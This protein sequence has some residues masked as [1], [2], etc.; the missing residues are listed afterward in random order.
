MHSSGLRTIRTEQER[1]T[2]ALLTLATYA[3]V[4]ET[5]GHDVGDRLK[6]MKHVFVPAHSLFSKRMRAFNLSF[7][8]YTHGPFTREV[9]EAWEELTIAGF[10]AVSEDPRGPVTVTGDGIAF[11]RYFMGE[12]LSRPR[13][14]G[15]L[16]EIEASVDA[17]ASLSTRQLLDRVYATRAVPVG[18][19]DRVPIAEIP[20]GVY[21]TKIIEP[22]EAAAA[23]DIPA[24]WHRRFHIAYLKGIAS[25]FGEDTPAFDGLTIDELEQLDK[26]LELEERDVLEE[27]DLGEIKSRYGI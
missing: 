14:Q 22:Y 20:A 21:L 9:Y 17:T 12:V 24:Q 25:I 27:V 23:V 8:R 7:H 11:A 5:R 19:Q 2:D 1:F 13:N 15:I 16:H 3:R 10:L 6:A 18:W 4:Q 26:A